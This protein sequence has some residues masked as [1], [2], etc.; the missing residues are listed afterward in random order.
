[1][2]LKL[3]LHTHCFEALY[4]P[5]SKWITPIIVGK[6]VASVKAKGLDGIA[7]TEHQQKEFGFV[8]KS[9]ISEQF[10][11]EVVII[12]GREIYLHGIHVV[13]LFLPN[14]TTFRFIPHPTYLE[15]LENN[16][17]FSRIHGIEIDN[18]CYDQHIDKPGVRAIAEK[19]NLLL[20]SNSDAHDIN[21]VGHYYNYIDLEDLFNRAEPHTEHEVYDY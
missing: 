12:P 2:K 11:N 13:E 17:D 16:F 15:H 3:D 8:A 21:N 7:V 18:H 6:I 19:H 9:I 4:V 10:N 20:M 14:K 5:S 1:M